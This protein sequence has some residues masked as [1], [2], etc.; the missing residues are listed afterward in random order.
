MKLFLK[1]KSLTFMIK[2]VELNNLYYVRETKNEYVQQVTSDEMKIKLWHQRMGRLNNTDLLKLSE[3]IEDLNFDVNKIHKNCEICLLGKQTALPFK[4][5]SERCK[6]SLEIIHS[7]I[8]RPF[9]INSM[10][11]VKYFITFIGNHSRWCITYLLR[12]KSDVLEMFKKYKNVAENWT[13]DKIK[14]L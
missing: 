3:Y 12:N 11:G 14:Y 7:D 2:R 10:G 8:C 13:G 1:R 5:R 9:N 4:S 6:K